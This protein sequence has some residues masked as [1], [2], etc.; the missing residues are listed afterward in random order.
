MAITENSNGH[1]VDAPEPIRGDRGAWLLGPRNVPLEIENPSVRLSASTDS[2][3]VPNLR[4]P[5]AQSRKRILSG[6]VLG[7]PTLAALSRLG[8]ARAPSIGF[9]VSSDTVGRVADG[10]IA[11]GQA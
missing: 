2:G 7:I 4:F 1:N 3:T 8:G 6:R 9:A 5:C 11:Q 10:L